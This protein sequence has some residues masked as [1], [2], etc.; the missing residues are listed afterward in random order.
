MN[1]RDIISALQRDGW[2][3]VAQ[4]GS[5]LQFK[6]PAKAGRVTV[7]HPK[8]DV[9]LGTFKSIEKQSGLKLR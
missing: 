5:H 9:P 6:H 7:P 3:Q 4:K 8:R 2:V 1:S